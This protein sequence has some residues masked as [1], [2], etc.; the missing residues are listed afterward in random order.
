[1]VHKWACGACACTINNGQ[2]MHKHDPNLER[3]REM[4]YMRN[5]VAFSICKFS[6]QDLTERFG[7][8][9]SSILQNTY[10]IVVSHNICLI[11]IM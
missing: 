5:T 3:G 7:Y 8:P 4:G 9:T 6:S 11:K 1:M 10:I 2:R